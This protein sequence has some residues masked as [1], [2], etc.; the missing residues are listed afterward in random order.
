M[1]LLIIFY[2]MSPTRYEYREF[3]LELISLEENFSRTPKKPSTSEENKNGREE[4]FINMLLVQAL[5]RHRDEMME[6]FSHILQRLP[7]ATKTSSSRNHFG[8]TSPFK[9]HVNF[10]ILVFEG[11]IDVDALKKWLNLLDGYFS[12][13]NFFDKENI[14][15][16]LLKDFPH[17]KHWWE[18]YQEKI[19]T[20]E[21]KKY[22]V[23]LTWDFFLDAIKEQYYPHDNY[24]D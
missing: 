7:I 18:N 4:D 14:I 16:S 12:I 23:E 8:V 11:Q 3:S 15:F 19:S 1:M 2:C 17:V 20:K 5:V 24:E 21:S 9:V 22:G 13:H 6:N 10:N